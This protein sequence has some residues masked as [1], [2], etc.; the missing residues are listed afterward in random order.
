MPTFLIE[1]LQPALTSGLPKQVPSASANAS[2]WPWRVLLAIPLASPL[3]TA[4]RL[5]TS[6]VPPPRSLA[7]LLRWTPG[8]LAV[9]AL[10]AL[11]VTVCLSLG[12]QLRTLTVS[13]CWTPETRGRKLIRLSCHVSSIGAPALLSAFSKWSVVSWT[14]TR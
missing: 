2:A 7:T 6:V 1:T 5:A 3:L 4:R 9:V 10:D 8:V 13:I 12:S 11:P 14:K